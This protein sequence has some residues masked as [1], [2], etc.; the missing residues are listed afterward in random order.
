MVLLVILTFGLVFGALPAWGHTEFVSS[1]PA[2]AET[3][4][5]PIDRIEVIFSGESH[6]AGDGFVV[7]DGA[8][9]EQIP[10]TS[11]RPTT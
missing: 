10:T 3:V 8:G 4:E 1:S 9:T 7:L 5:Q 11:L 6:P 2:D